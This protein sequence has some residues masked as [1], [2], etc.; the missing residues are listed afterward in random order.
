MYGNVW[1]N[2]VAGFIIK[3]TNLQRLS[4]V[5]IF[6]FHLKACVVVTIRAVYYCA[7]AFSV[8]M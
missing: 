7:V 4:V 5:R 6:C 2:D 8:N 1:L 3:F